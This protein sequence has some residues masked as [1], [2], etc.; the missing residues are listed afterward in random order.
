MAFETN[1]NGFLIAGQSVF[2][3]INA[4]L[5]LIAAILLLI[6]LIL[7]KSR[8][9]NAHRIAMVSAFFVSTIFL[10]CYV[11]YHATNTP[12]RFPAATFPL[13][14]KFYW[15]LLGTHILLAVTV[16]ILAI[17]SIYLG[18]K[19]LRQKHRR[20]AKIAFPIWMYVSVTG[21]LI[22]LMLYW[23]FPAPTPVN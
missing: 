16:P 12:N 23:W 2:P 21:V 20:I 8:K 5:N 13:A 14:A 10:A 9:E 4:S 18:W 22:Y 1:L 19:N 6:G 7:I 15:V 11:T 3:H 17:W